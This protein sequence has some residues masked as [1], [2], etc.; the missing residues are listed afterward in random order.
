MLVVFPEIMH[1]VRHGGM[2][3]CAALCTRKSLSTVLSIQR[4]YNS[5]IYVVCAL[6][7]PSYI[8]YIQDR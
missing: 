2:K 4:T 7:K 5:A 8:A 6:C 1:S 3:P